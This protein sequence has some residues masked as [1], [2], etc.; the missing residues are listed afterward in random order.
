MTPSN[1][2]H[3]G[4]NPNA[5]F[6]HSHPIGRSTKVN[7]PKRENEN[8]QRLETGRSAGMKVDGH[9]KISF[10]IDAFTSV[11][12]WLIFKSSDLIGQE[13]HLT[14][15]NLNTLLSGRSKT[16]DSSSRPRHQCH[17]NYTC[18][19]W[20]VSCMAWNMPHGDF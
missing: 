9:A 13:C 15:I 2:L 8:Q 1:I 12:D 17:I 3:I 4:S 20:S 19:I 6:H 11:S 5:V 7:G 14:S 16:I 10:Q 18:T